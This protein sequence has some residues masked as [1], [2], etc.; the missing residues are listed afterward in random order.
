MKSY[1]RTMLGKKSK[2][3]KKCFDGNFIGTNFL[4]TADLTKK[5]SENWRNFNRELTPVCTASHNVS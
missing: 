1:Y 4:I 2:F 5:L 3:A